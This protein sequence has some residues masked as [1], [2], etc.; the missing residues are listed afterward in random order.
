MKSFWKFLL[1]RSLPPNFLSSLSFAVIG[2]GDSSYQKFNFVA[3]RLNKRLLNLGANSILPLCL[4][5]DQH[6]LGI[7]GALNPWLC[8]FWTII[9]E[10]SPLPVGLSILPKS[11]KKIRWPVKRVEISTQTNE[12]VDI[13]SDFEHTSDDDALAEVVVNQINLK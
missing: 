6:D 12:I 11:F 10:I 1:R 4:C 8:D 5:D 9:I 13:F 2:L 7:A 3:K